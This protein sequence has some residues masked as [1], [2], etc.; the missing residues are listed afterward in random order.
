MQKLTTFV[1]KT[2]ENR[3][4]FF[5]LADEED[6]EKRRVAK[7]LLTGVLINRKESCNTCFVLQERKGDEY[8]LKKCSKCHCAWY[9]SVE[10]QRK[11][12]PQHKQVCF[13]ETAENKTSRVKKE[14]QV[15]LSV[16]LSFTKEID[17]KE[18]EFILTYIEDPV[19]FLENPLRLYEP[20]KIL[21]RKDLA[22]LIPKTAECPGIFRQGFAVFAVL[23]K[24]LDES[25][26]TFVFSIENKKID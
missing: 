3:T 21:P 18:D 19:K 13:S 9:C 14:I 10:C 23:V 6:I 7:E 2:Q 5:D 16:L 26:E 22:E 17:M 8:S 25:Y 24:L 15:L 11:D 20:L 4:L 12:W 1:A